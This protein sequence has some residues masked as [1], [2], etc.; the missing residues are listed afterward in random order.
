MRDPARELQEPCAS[1][2]CDLWSAVIR[3]L[4][5]GERGVVSAILG[6]EDVIRLEA[7]V[8]QVRVPS[9]FH[10]ERLLARHMAGIRRALD[11]L[12]PGTTVEIVVGQPDTGP[13]NSD[14][15]TLDLQAPAAATQVV[16]DGLNERF[17]FESF[18]VGRTNHLAHNAAL[19]VAENPSGAYNPLFIH[20][21]SGNGKTHLLNAIGLYLREHS[22]RLALRYVTAERFTAEFIDGIKSNNLDSFKRRYRRCAFLLVDDVQFLAGKAATQEEFFHTF[23]DVIGPGGRV[24]MAADRHP[25]EIRTLAEPLRSRLKS[26]L[27][28]DL[29]APELETRIAI[30]KNKA[31]AN[32]AEVSDEVLELIAGRVSRNVRELEG[33]LIRVL[34]DASL[35]VRPVTL[36]AA[37]QS[38]EAFCGSAARQLTLSTI[39]EEAALVFG[40]SVEELCGPSRTRALVAA[41]RATMYL[42]RSLTSESLPAIGRSFGDRDHSTVLHSVRKVEKL[43]I[44][45]TAVYGKVVELMNRLGREVSIASSS[46]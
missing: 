27:V 26:G 37:E 42:C 24:V 43:M 11:E 9:A 7:D 30:L 25:G 1:R 12:A 35:S 41:R 3:R 5:S 36:Q 44:E 4:G 16:H 28:A 32:H 2:A 38:L 13:A 18:V 10:R 19:C 31:E 23:N 46:T 29:H 17:S 33:A 34:A 15:L 14:Q 21:A 45:R 39:I 22:P 20:G 40:V 6:T 8:L